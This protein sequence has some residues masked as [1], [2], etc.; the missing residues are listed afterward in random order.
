[1]K[2]TLYFLVVSILITSCISI[3]VGG[4]YNEYNKLTETQKENVV[5]LDV[6][7]SLEGL[8]NDGRV[9]SITGKQLKRELMKQDTSLVYFWSP[10]CES[11]ICVLVEACQEYASQKKYVNQFFHLFK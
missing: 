1:M 11:E 2:K 10:H 5:F 9:Y 4:I 7:K 3:S 6:D 8:N